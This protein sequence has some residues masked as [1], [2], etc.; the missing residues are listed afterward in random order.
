MKDI[1]G[2]KVKKKQMEKF[3]KK[4]FSIFASAIKDI[5]A[6]KEFYQRTRKSILAYQRRID[7]EYSYG[8]LIADLLDEV[9][10]QDTIEAR[11]AKIDEISE[12]IVFDE[13]K[14]KDIC[15]VTKMERESSAL[16]YVM[17]EKYKSQKFSPVL[18]RQRCSAIK[19]N[20]H[21][22]TVSIL[23]N[24]IIIFESTLDKIYRILI[25]ENPT[26]YFENQ[27][28]SLAAVFSNIQ[29]A[30]DE[31]IDSEVDAK[32]YNSL[33]FLRFLEEKENIKI[34]RYEQLKMQFTE[35]Y[36]RRNSYVHTD[37]RAN[38]KYLHNV[39][40]KFTVGV[41]EDDLLVCDDIYIDNAI[42]VLTKILFSIIFE[43]LSSRK[44]DCDL[45]GHISGYFFSKLKKS[46]Y[47]IASYGYYVLSKYSELDFKDRTMY[48]INYINAE[49]QLHNDETVKNELD[50][51]DVS[52]ATDN[53]KIAKECLLDNNEVVF[54][55]LID[56]Y[57]DSYNAVEI[58]TWPI[59][60]NF[61]E[62]RYYEDFVA[63]H[64]ADFE[65]EEIDISDDE[66]IE[67]YLADDE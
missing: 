67:G 61:R 56:S 54:E 63:L 51:L 9:F 5:E 37:G 44:A 6:L 35:I 7:D 25:R 32:I 39:D 59:F 66:I 21:I 12:A 53:F 19:K 50:G 23:S 38:K 20:E 55:M 26:T 14:L 29:K 41:E 16:Y 65:T 46:E 24:I 58:K 47:Q 10:T 18:A 4:Y 48:R 34:D 64:R 49:K 60:I 28:I 2:T 22:L 33:D 43:L 8:K 3:N 36:F 42:L 31:K 30:L 1:G 40:K 57:P 15:E 62:S 27:S 11:N 45:V 17:N 13:V 52:I